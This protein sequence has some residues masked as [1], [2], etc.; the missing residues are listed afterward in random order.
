MSQCLVI[1]RSWLLWSYSVVCNLQLCSCTTGGSYSFLLQLIY[2]YYLLH[3]QCK[4]TN[5]LPCNGFPAACFHA[6]MY[7]LGFTCRVFFFIWFLQFNTCRLFR[8]RQRKKQFCSL[9]LLRA[10]YTAVGFTGDIKREGQTL[11]L[12]SSLPPSLLSHS[13]HLPQLLPPPSH[14]PDPLPSAVSVW[15]RP[16]PSLLPS[17]FP[18]CLAAIS[19]T[20]RGEP[21]E[22][23]V[24]ACAHVC[25]PSWQE[26]LI[27]CSGLGYQMISICPVAIFVQQ[28]KIEFP[29]SRC[30][31]LMESPIPWN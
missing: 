8:R 16:R 30:S 21:C 28:C 20:H 27:K 14:S 11:R 12:S 10:H 5:I 22:P 15:L 3:K 23:H 31:I 18:S 13:Y 9:L 26:G 29:S 2:M 24:S 25:S 4:Y 17:F 19:Y 6:H 1:K 7:L